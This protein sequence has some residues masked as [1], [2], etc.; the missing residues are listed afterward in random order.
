MSTRV[1]SAVDR[2]RNRA[3]P[4]NPDIRALVQWYDYAKATIDEIDALAQR[5]AS[6]QSDTE[7]LAKILEHCPQCNGTQY[8]PLIW[9]GHPDNP[10]EPTQCNCVEE[11]IAHLAQL[12]EPVEPTEVPF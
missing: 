7:T 6:L 11:T 9:D 8:G 4:D 10:P 3:T 12:H 1:D 2:L 5:N